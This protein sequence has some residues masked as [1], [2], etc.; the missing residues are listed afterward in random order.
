MVY[1]S[2]GYVSSSIIDMYPHVS[3]SIHDSKPVG[4]WNDLLNHS[5]SHIGCCLFL[6][7]IQALCC[8]HRRQGK[9]NIWPVLAVLRAPTYTLASSNRRDLSSDTGTASCAACT[10]LCAVLISTTTS[11]MRRHLLWV[12]S[13]LSPVELWPGHRS[14]PKNL[15]KVGSVETWSLHM[16]PSV[17]GG[18]GGGGDFCWTLECLGRLSLKTPSC[19]LCSISWV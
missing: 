4:L 2:G 15:F 9:A 14:I 7:N 11:G 1:V 5:T 18:G 17:S 19:D 16:Q 13:H 8:S 3:F 6:F 12:C 10:R